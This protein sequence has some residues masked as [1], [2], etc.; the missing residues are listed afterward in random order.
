MTDPDYSILPPA[1]LQSP[2]KR[3]C[4]EC[5]NKR[6]V[7]IGESTVV[8]KNVHVYNPGRPEEVQVL[9]NSDA[10]R[11]FYRR[12]QEGEIFHLDSF[13]QCGQVDHRVLALAVHNAVMAFNQAVARA[14]EPEPAAVNPDSIDIQTSTGGGRVTGSLT[15]GQKESLRRA[16][17][18]HVHVAALLPD[19]HIACLFYIVLAVESV[20]LS[21]GLELRC[22]ESIVAVDNSG[23]QPVDLSEYTDY[24][25]SLLRGRDDRPD[26]SGGSSSGV[27][28]KASAASSQAGPSSGPRQRGRPC[29]VEGPCEQQHLQGLTKFP[30][31]LR[32]GERPP[33]EQ[34]ASRVGRLPDAETHLRRLLA[35]LTRK[36]AAAGPGS[37]E[38]MP[39]GRHPARSSGQTVGHS[40]GTLDLSATVHAAAAR[41]ITTARPMLTIAAGDL[42]F[43]PRPSAPK[44]DICFILD[45]SASMAGERL[46][47]A[48]ALILRLL[49]T[50]ARRVSVISFQEDTAELAI[51]F[52]ANPAVVRSGLGSIQARGSTPLAM[53]LAM[54]LDYLGRVPAY[55]P[56][57]VLMSDGLPSYASGNTSDPVADALKVARQIKL[58]GHAFTCLALTPRQHYLA[59]LAAV[60]G[61]SLHICRLAAPVRVRTPDPPPTPMNTLVR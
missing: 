20:I 45:A 33:G 38:R 13:H 26:F 7:R 31:N 39:A 15:H 44:A 4:A 49:S 11:L 40:A 28:G 34:A 2:A 16:H 60:A 3:L 32:P 46:Q 56:L 30:S 18:N 50:A 51:S 59:E 25:D 22:V 14:E 35:K 52:T 29:P 21:A 12:Q 61:G 27:S 58:R 42:R 43:Q 1:R 5:R 9:R 55:S 36:N 57:L 17:I 54:G 48:K 10:G 53:G 37:G 19:T 24:S 41:M 8:S 6:G 47:A 23:D